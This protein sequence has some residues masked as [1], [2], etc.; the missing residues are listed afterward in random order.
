MNYLGTDSLQSVICKL[1]LASG[2]KGTVVAKEGL[3][4]TQWEKTDKGRDLD[5]G[6]VQS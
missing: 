6:A 3:P 2:I 5:W 1:L 4:G